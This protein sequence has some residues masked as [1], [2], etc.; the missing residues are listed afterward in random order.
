MI[1]DDDPATRIVLADRLEMGGYQVVVAVD[2]LEGLRYLHTTELLPDLILLDLRMPRM[3]GW[4]FLNVQ[5]H[6]PDLAHIPIVLLSA[7]SDLERNAATLKVKEYQE[8]PIRAAALLGIVERYCALSIVA[9]ECPSLVGNT[10]Q[11]D[12][13]Q[14]CSLLPWSFPTTNIPM[15]LRISHHSIARKRSPLAA[16]RCRVTCADRP[17]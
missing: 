8:K 17:R 1:I 16:K 12:S 6:D 10:A 4:Q 11:F 15:R 7:A 2:G 5:R 13:R 9:R 3:D 14:S